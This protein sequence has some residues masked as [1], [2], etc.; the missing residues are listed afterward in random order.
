ME[1]KK[2]KDKYEELGCEFLNEEECQEEVE[3]EGLDLD[4]VERAHYGEDEDEE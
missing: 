3:E 2:Q 4:D 1:T